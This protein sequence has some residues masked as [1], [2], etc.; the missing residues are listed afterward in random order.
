M[1]QLNRSDGDALEVLRRTSLNANHELARLAEDVIAVRIVRS[2]HPGNLYTA[3]MFTTGPRLTAGRPWWRLSRTR[4][5][6][7]SGW[8]GWRCGS[9]NAVDQVVTGRTCTPDAGWRVHR[10]GG[11][12]IIRWV[13]RLAVSA[14]AG[15]VTR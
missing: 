5:L 14:D 15:S 10:L 2:L 4:S 9:K 7:S 6:T 8:S 1:A 3:D 11:A 12:G 13:G